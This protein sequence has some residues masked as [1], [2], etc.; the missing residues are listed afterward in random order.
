MHYHF[1]LKQKKHPMRANYFIVILVSVIV[2]AADV[3]CFSADIVMYGNSSKPP[4]VYL[5]KSEP[6][7]ILIEILEYVESKSD[8]SFDI[9]LL[10]WKRAFRN[11][12]MGMGGIIGFSKTEERLKYL[13]FSDAMYFDDIMIVVLKKKSFSFMNMTDL[14]GK[15]IGARRGSSY[16]DEFERGKRELFTIAEDTDSIQRLKKLLKER[17]DAALVGPGKAG[18]HHAI[19]SDPW[20][21]MHK[22]EFMILDRPLVRDPNY[23]GFSKKLNMQKFLNEFNRILIKGHKDGTIQNIIDQYSGL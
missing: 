9:K 23:I 20:L 17:I 18:V 14:A 10:P 11:A 16:G 3:Y 19:H 15:L 5:E 2:L 22:D 1:E 7:G 13:D 12:D 4:K 6:K 8:Y 21:Q